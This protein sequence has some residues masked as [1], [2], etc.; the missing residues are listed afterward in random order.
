MR[1][2]SFT[3]TC[4]MLADWNKY[5]RMTDTVDMSPTQGV[6]D[7]TSVE[8]NN[9]CEELIKAG[10]EYVEGTLVPQP[11]CKPPFTLSELKNA[12]PPHCFER[13]M[14]KSFG[15]LALDFLIVAS[16]ACCAYVVLELHNLPFLAQLIGY[17]L[18]WFCQGS[19]LFGVWVLAHECGHSAFSESD[20]VNDTVG[21]VVHS[22]LLTPYHS[23]KISHRMHHSNTGSCEHDQAFVPFT[24][25]DLEP[26]W[27]DA[28]E[29]SPIYNLYK[30]SKILLIGWMPGY[31]AFNGWGP[32]KYDNKP[33]S[34]FNPNAALFSSKERHLVV[35]SDVGVVVALVAIGYIVSIWGF[36]IVFRMYFVPYFVMNA[37]L[38]TVTYLHHTDTYVPH[39]REGEWSWLRGSLCTVDRSYGKILD[40]VLHHITDTHICHHIFSKMPFYH[41][42]EATEAIK[43]ILGKYYL[44]DSTPVFSALWR[45]GNHCKYIQ[46]DGNVVF[47]KKKFDKESAGAKVP[48]VKALDGQKTASGERKGSGSGPSSSRG[49]LVPPEKTGR[50]PSLII[51]DGERRGSLL[52]KAIEGQINQESTP[53]RDAGEVGKPQIVDMYDSYSAV[54]GEIGYISVQVQGS[55]AP[56]FKFYY[57]GVTPL[58][59]GVRYKFHTDGETNTVTLCMRNIKSSD[60]GK[61]KIVFTNCH[62]TVSDETQLYVS[63]PGCTDFRA[64]L[65]KSKYAKWGKEKGDPNWG[66]LKGVQKA[67]DQF[68]TPLQDV[69]VKEGRDKKVEF[70][71]KF[72]KQNAKAKWF[73]RKNELFMGVKYKF[74]NDGDIYQLTVLNPKL[75]DSAKYTIDISG[76]QSSATLTVEAPDPTYR[77]LRP[78]DKKYDGFTRHELILECKVSDPIAIVSWYRGEVKLSSND[79]CIID[80]D[81]AGVCSLRIKSCNLDDTGDYKCQLERQPDKTDTKVKVIEYP[82]KF[83]KLL[84]SQQNVEK[85]T[86][87]LACELDDPLGDV[88]WLKNGKEIKADPNRIQIIKDGR[89]RKLVIKD[90]KLSDADQYS[91]VSNADKTEA[92]L[93]IR[94]QN[95]FNKSLKDTVAVE[96]EK[97]IFEIELEDDKATVEWKLK[98]KSIKSSDRVEIKNLGGGK[99]QLVFNSLKLSDAGEITAKSGE[100]SS[101]CKLTVEKGETKPQINAPNEFEGTVGAPLVLE[102]P[103][104]IDGKKQT[105]IEALLLKDGKPFPSKDVEVQIKDDKVIFTIKKPTRD[106]SGP[107]QIKLSNGQGNDVKD[108]KIALHDVP[109]TPQDVIVKE[110]FEKSCVIDWKSPKDNGGTPIQKYVIERQDISSKKGWESAGEVPAD[111]PTTFKVENLTP[112]NKYKFRILAVNKVGQS[113]P[114]EFKSEIL[115]KNPWKE[116]GKTKNLQ[117]TDW[118]KDQ[119]KIKWIKPDQDGGAE[120][121]EYEIEVKDKNSKD[122]VKKK[123]VPATETSTT[124]DGLKDGQQYEFRV[125]AVNKAGPGEPSD[126]IKPNK[127]KKLLKD[128]VSVERE[129]LVLDIE[130]EDDSAP[131][132]W[133]QNGKVIKPSD[134][135]EIKNLGGGKH[136]L[137]FKTLKISDAG[138][139]SVKSGDLVSTCKLTVEKGESKPQ[140]NGPKDFEGSV[141]VPLVLEV[142]FKIDGKKQTPIEALLMK[143]GKPLPS[144]EVEVQVMDGKIVFTIPK[145]TRDH[146]GPYQIKLSN[147]QGDDVKDVKITLSD[148]PKAPQDVI[149]KEVFEKSCVID[150]KSP[151]DNGGAP[152]QKYVIE[153]QDISSKKGWESA[154]EVPADKPS[155]FKVENLTPNNKYK[156]RI[157]AVNKVGQ[158]EPTE[159]K[160]E[161]LAKNP[162]S[163]PSKPKNLQV[164]D[165]DKDQAKIKWIKPDQDGGAEITEYEIE[166][167]DKNS[168]DWVKKKRVPATE[169]STTLDGLKDGQQYEIRLRAVNKAGPG[170]PSDAIKPNKFKKLLKDTVS[171]ERET[172][173]LDI[174]LEDDSAPVEWKQNGKVIKPSDNVEIKNL[175]GGKHQLVFKTLKISD[176]GEISVKSG[177]LVSTC[178]LTVEKGE[179]KPQINA[180]KDFEGSV[181]V[182]LVLEV[183]F[184]I[185]GKKQTPIEALLMKDGKPLPSKEV[186]VQVMDGKIVF[187]IPKP[188]R[189]HSGPYQI[190][191]S[192]GQGDDVKDVKITLSDVPKAPQDVIVKEVFEKSCVIDWKSPKDNGGAPIQK[193]VIERQDISS[194]KGWESAGEVPADK[195][196]TFKVENLTPN[197]KYKFRIV[198]VNKVGQSE[199]TEFKSEVLAKNPWSEPSK[200]KNLQVTDWDKDQA[201]IKWIKPDQDGGAEITEYEIEVKDKNS[202]DWVKKKRVP[203]TETSTTL[204]GL[205]DGQQYEIR[206][207]AVNKAG[208]GE[209]SDA[210]KPN[211]FKKLLKDTVGVERETL[212]LDIEIEDDSAPIEWKQNGKII[213]PSDNVEIKNLGGGK[214]QLVFKTLKIP[215]AGEIS[216]KSGDLVS[217]CKLSVDKGESKPQIN[218]PKDFEGSVGVPLV[219][220]VPFKIDGKKQTPIEALL[221][222]DG[223]PLPS[224]EVEVQVMDGKIVFTVPKP[225]RDHSGPYQI[226]L[227]NGQGDDVKDV[228]VILHDV[229]NAPQDVIVKEVFEKSCVIDWKSPKDSGGT[230]IQKYVIE[231]QDISSKKGWESVGE[232]PA[233][234]PTT[235]KVENL[236][237]N[238]KYKFR[239]VAVNKVGQSEPTEFKSEILAKNPWS[240]PSKPKNLQV[241]DWEKD[242]AKIKWIKPDQDGGAEITEYEIEVKDKNSK[243]WVKKKRVPAT[244]TSTTLDGLKDGEKYEF[245]LRAVNK[246]GPGEPSD[247]IKP[248]K[249]KKLLKD[250]EGVERE[251]LVLDI[252]LEDDSA[253]VEWKQNGKV[254]KPSDNVEIKN[255]GGGK[256]QLVFKTLKI[257]DA[258]EISVKSGDLV[259]ACKLTL[260]K[261]ET[262]PQINVP[263]DFEGSVGVPLVLEVPFKIDGKKQTPIEALL[264]KDGKPLPSK[265]VEVQVMDGKIVFTIPKP[266]RDHSGPYQIKLSNGQGNDVKDVKITLQDVPNSPQDVSVKDVFEKSCVIDWKSPKDNGGTP[267]QKYVIERQDISS[268]KGWE[269]VGEVSADKPTTFKVE[270]LTPNNKYKLRVLA[271]N[272]VGQSV[273]A[274]FKNEVLAKNPW[275]EPSKPKNLEV[276]DWDKDHAKLK[277]TKPDKDGGAEIIEYEIEVKDEITKEWVKRKR[278]SVSET[279]TIIEGLIE[280]HQ[281]EF[282]VRAINKAGPGEPSDAT[283]PIIAKCRFVKPFITSEQ[284]KKIVIKKGQ[285]F[286]YNVRFGGEPA[287]KAKWE[288]DYKIIKSDGSRIKIENSEQSTILTFTNCVRTDSGKYK[289]FLTNSSGT[290]ESVGEVIVLDKPSEPKGPLKVSDIHE[291]GCKLK[292]K[293]PDD[294]GGV[295]I[296]Q[297]KIEKLDSETN[298]WSLVTKISSETTEYTVTDLISGPEYKFRVSAV[299]DEGESDTLITESWTVTKKTITEVVEYADGDEVGVAKCITTR[300]ENIGDRE[301][302]TKTTVT[303]TTSTNT[304]Q[305][306]SGRIR[307]E[308]VKRI[309]TR[310]TQEE[311]FCPHFCK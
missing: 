99:H 264:M 201:K 281:Y 156:F 303:T 191:L 268:K 234:K 164:T 1:L 188:T 261:G 251:S 230:P 64:M 76:V 27:S 265:E 141:G 190:K 101:T 205:K 217:T 151:K 284:L 9:N 300:K 213:K 49:Q 122:W 308:T 57:K 35:L 197:N 263:K 17:S 66:D 71:A 10:Y 16:L 183:P 269:T 85:D 91:C 135:V 207:R 253:P 240:E 93:T 20:F 5:Y 43:P 299:N 305:D 109:N 226:K 298:T 196:S 110:V 62:G 179:S 33:K 248:N 96:R 45:V 123:R 44:R 134:N 133:K 275:D 131:V 58:I 272:K 244:E 249:F 252:E 126:A 216:V 142:P 152:I 243:D 4:S 24:Q 50:R 84:K 148:V 291:N 309:V 165:W 103:F 175:G 78:L 307:T 67:Q 158:S 154:G 34:H 276:T 292:W 90:V 283:K 30:L 237:P 116:P 28:L 199:P 2:W 140:I 221:L 189:D 98:G 137:V 31:L 149:V 125:R 155:T 52:A 63:K 111:K 168:K 100:L 306:P 112:N 82:Y 247:A 211:K 286:S 218:A 97:V 178:K 246:A 61:Y 161:V 192:N 42:V 232:V 177:D 242:Q 162:W 193:Y 229:P 285:Q 267:I 293:S 282:R 72:T 167:K 171:V 271:V 180:P 37:Y 270:N 297:Y 163:E 157:V 80:K 60:E 119:A 38:V 170:E 36:P 186:E 184:K 130:L 114:A 48:Q 182:P 128:T 132:E 209:P 94:K 259:S 124:L 13:S 203:A 210:I 115:A 104:K 296:K 301:T 166:V 41:C 212:V 231:R 79:R 220:E 266:T 127:F 25:S 235:F 260:E 136:Q 87:T 223:K 169:T 81:L 21:L 222:K 47:Y 147:G 228:K 310:T 53:L 172:L 174:E 289:L 102:V 236:T 254:I 77:F 89:V 295:S 23:W 257:S 69:T 185:D 7:K 118:E 86:V 208:P 6:I 14:I 55:P 198:A 214:H 224:K 75:E 68:V 274:E 73:C 3:T 120:I 8:F 255:L 150:W 304:V 83:M 15:Y 138:E 153:R 143:D 187:T 160:S 12:I 279:T 288:K 32:R 18:Y 200:P 129:T 159:F 256:H 88:K 107:Y 54:E 92:E 227:S 106:L 95:K 302:T 145:P 70:L 219:L 311:Q 113:V 46:N 173:V 56:T 74:R 29:D 215:D 225:T 250:T 117:V 121:T 39:F 176:A 258:G 181:G 108:V 238:N 65:R 105:P 290:I 202:K 206:L 195:P 204:D 273:P 277:W 194:K 146:S 59:E 245:R 51:G 233:D 22:A 144:K 241:T 40:V 294:D 139:I 287:P 239:I 280:S 262:K 278:V 11:I 26:T 19:V